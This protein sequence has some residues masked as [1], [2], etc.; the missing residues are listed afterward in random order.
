[1]FQVRRKSENI[2]GSYPPLNLY[3]DD[4]FAEKLPIMNA[5]KQNIDAL[6]KPQEV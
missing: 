4:V 1:M 5:S 6:E 3:A 2:V